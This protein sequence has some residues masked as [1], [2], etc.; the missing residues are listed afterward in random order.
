[1]F[2]HR[3]DPHIYRNHQPQA[4][5][6]SFCRYLL[7]GESLVWMFVHH[8]I[9]KPLERHVTCH[10]QNIVPRIDLVGNADI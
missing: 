7:E 9:D 8:F 4:L 2:L 10:F 5:P 6:R 3:L 1:M